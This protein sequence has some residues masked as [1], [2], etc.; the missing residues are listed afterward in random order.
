[1]RTTALLW[2]APAAVVIALSSGC[3]SGATVASDTHDSVVT[4]PPP[5]PPPATVN[6]TIQDFA[7]APA[8]LSV[9]KGQ[10][11]VW[12]NK[13]PSAHTVTSDAATFDSGN[14]APPAGTGY[15]ATAGQTFAFTFTQTG[16]FPYHCTLHPQ[17]TGTVTVTP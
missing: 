8:T 11:V 6:V 2:A 5:P 3:D 13:G 4:P 17:M 10:T 16:T 7:Y 15:N 12:T 9:T 14:L 1:M